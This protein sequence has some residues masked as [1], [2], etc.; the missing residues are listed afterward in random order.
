MSTWNTFDPY[1][2]W[3]QMT[4]HVNDLAAWKNIPPEL[5]LAW[6]KYRCVVQIIFISNVLFWWLCMLLNISD[7]FFI[8]FIQCSHH[9]CRLSLREKCILVSFSNIRSNLVHSM[10]DASGSV[11]QNGCYPVVV[12]LFSPNFRSMGAQQQSHQEDRLINAYCNMFLH[13]YR[14]ILC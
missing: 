8:I 4:L 5:E 13:E 10:T 11:V 1:L 14:Y 7:L 3:R 12:S 6:Q 2:L 9:F